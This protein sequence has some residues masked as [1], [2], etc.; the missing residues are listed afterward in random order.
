MGAFEII[1]GKK[2][3]GEITPQGA[4]NEALQV[5]NAV[6]LTDQEVIINNIPDIIDVNKLIDLLKT[7]GV[8]IKKIGKGSYSFLADEVDVDTMT[9]EEFKRKG[10]SLRGCV[11]KKY[12]S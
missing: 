3:K 9:S 11:L 7:L 8:K 4:K 12:V 10:A 2:L 6:L 5:I 1:G